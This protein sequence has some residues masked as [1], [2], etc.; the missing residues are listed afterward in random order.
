VYGI[1]WAL[2]I[3]NSMVWDGS[4]A[5]AVE[6]MVYL[7]LRRNYPRVRYY[8]TRNK[9]QELDFL[10]SND[11]G[12]PIMAVQISLDIS[13]PDTLRRELDPLISTARYFGTKQ[14]I[15]VTL[16]QEQRFERDGIV[17]HALPAWR[18]LLQDSPFA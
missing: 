4:Y 18:W 2:A 1:D 3:R 7:Q 10:V 5:R 12:K 8:L 15:V 16:S 11:C 6:N 13:L 14:N 9:R 17:V